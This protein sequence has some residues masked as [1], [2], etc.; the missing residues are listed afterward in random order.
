MNLETGGS[1][2]VSDVNGQDLQEVFADD[3]GRGDFVILS[4][5]PE[6]YIQS[7]GEGDGPYTLEYRDGGEHHH[8]SAVGEFHKD[9]VLRAF[10]W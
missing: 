4:H 7:A 10:Q 9:D 8:F 3:K 1:L 2:S 6:T 5:A